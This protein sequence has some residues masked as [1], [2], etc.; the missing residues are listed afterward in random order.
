M[1][2]LGDRPDKAYNIATVPQNEKDAVLSDC[3][4]DRS[5]MD[6]EGETGHAPA[7]L[8]NAYAELMQTGHDRTSGMWW[9]G[10]SA[11]RMCS[12]QICNMMLSC[13]Y[14]YTYIHILIHNFILFSVGTVFNVNESHDHYI[15]VSEC[16]TMLKCHNDSVTMN[17]ALKYKFKCYNNVTIII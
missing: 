14:G 4:S 1:L 3:D 8:L 6:C 12:R 5:D 17:I 13:Q 16:C 2:D 9:N 15:V 11:S 10:R 7:R